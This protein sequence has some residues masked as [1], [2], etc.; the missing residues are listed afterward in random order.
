M[1][2]EEED[3]EEGVAHR[4]ARHDQAERHDVG[5]LA[6]QRPVHPL[7]LL[8][9]SLVREVA[10]RG[11]DHDGDGERNAEPEDDLRIVVV[12][13]GADEE[14]GEKRAELEA[15]PHVRHHRRPC[16]RLRLHELGVLALAEEVA[17]RDLQIREEEQHCGH[18]RRVDRHRRQHGEGAGA[19]DRRAEDV[20]L[21]VVAA[22]GVGVGHDADGALDGPGRHAHRHHRLARVPVDVQRL[23]AVR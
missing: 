5:V 17:G 14:G 8:R 4:D 23:L 7:L 1:L 3:V 6:D 10:E 15:P 9:H 22:E 20:V 21:L 18:R 19:E 11:G 12:C 13:D 2:V 16:L